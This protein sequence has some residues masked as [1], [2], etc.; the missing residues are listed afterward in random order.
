M[1]LKCIN[2]S[3]GEIL[4]ILYFIKKMYGVMIS[5]KIPKYYISFLQ[6]QV[7]S[8]IVFVASYLKVML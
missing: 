5:L 1:K 2:M 4:S 3:F 7:T 8:F 6:L